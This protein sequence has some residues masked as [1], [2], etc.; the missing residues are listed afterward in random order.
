[1]PVGSSGVHGAVSF[2]RD[3]FIVVTPVE[4]FYG[5]WRND[6]GEH[7]DDDHAGVNFVIE[8]TTETTQFYKD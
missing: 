3:Q 6:G 7:D 4:P 2:I 1:M 5:E 8:D